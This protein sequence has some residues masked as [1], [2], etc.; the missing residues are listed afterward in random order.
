MAGL[1]MAII[2]GSSLSTFS[3]GINA[4]AANTVEDILK[5][6]LRRVKESTAT[7]VTRLVV[8][9]FGIAITG[10]AYGAKTLKGP[11]TQMGFSVIWGLWGARCGS[12]F[13]R[14]VCPMEQQIWR[15]GR[16]YRRSGPEPVARHRKPMSWK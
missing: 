11:V 14:G 1:Y 15:H 8:F 7:L 4:L 9:V 2:F 5:P 13:S 10:L 16:G 12:I 3:S 6:S